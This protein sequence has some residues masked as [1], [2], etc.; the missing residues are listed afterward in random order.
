MGF[1]ASSVVKNLPAKQETQ[2]RSLGWEYP[3]EEG[4]ETH[5][6]TL[7]WRIPVDRAAWRATVNGVTKNRT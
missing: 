5:S 1:P 7:A 2:V 4:M 6:S 3:L